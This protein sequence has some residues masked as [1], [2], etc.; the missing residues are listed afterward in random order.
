MNINPSLTGQFQLKIFREIF[1]NINK[2]FCVY[3][4][5]PNRSSLYNIRACLTSRFFPYE[6]A[7]EQVLS[8]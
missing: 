6:I 3:K 5:D 2:Y 4:K 1:K 7:H 8:I